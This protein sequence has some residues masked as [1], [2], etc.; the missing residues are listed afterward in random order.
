[1]D[2]EERKKYFSQLS[3]SVFVHFQGDSVLGQ[4]RNRKPLSP[5]KVYQRLYHKTVLSDNPQLRKKA[6]KVDCD[7]KAEYIIESGHAKDVAGKI[8]CAAMG[9]P[10]D[11]VS[12]VTSVQSLFDIADKMGISVHVLWKPSGYS[13]SIV[14]KTTDVV[15]MKI[16]DISNVRILTSTIIDT[17]KEWM[18]RNISRLSNLS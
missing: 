9:M 1:M 13:A 12:K 7:V 2:K 8:L 11:I 15:L 16:H 3:K 4:D 17:V 6:I 18:H 5:D 14:D 10:D